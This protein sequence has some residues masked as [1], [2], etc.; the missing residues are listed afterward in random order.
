MKHLIAPT[1]DVLT[2]GLLVDY[3]ATRSLFSDILVGETLKV[4][5]ERSDRGKLCCL[6][7]FET[8]FNNAVFIVLPSFL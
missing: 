1:V 8:V 2:V 6:K 5:L 4:L 7:F 3:A